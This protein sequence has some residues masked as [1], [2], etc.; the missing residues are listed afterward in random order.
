[1]LIQKVYQSLQEEID[2]NKKL[3]SKFEKLQE[4]EK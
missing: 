2:K 1:M 4:Q 3:E